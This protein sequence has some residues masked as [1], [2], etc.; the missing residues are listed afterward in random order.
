M[1]TTVIYATFDG[2][3][4]MQHG[5]GTQARAFVSALA[6]IELAGEIEVTVAY[7]E[8]LSDC[9]GYVRSADVHAATVEACRAA[10]VGLTPLRFENAR[11]WQQGAWLEI[12]T[13]LV[14][15]IGELREQGRRVVVLAVDAVF[16]PL[17]TLTA[18]AFGRDEQLDLVHVLYSS[19]R[20]EGAK[21]DPMREAWEQ[22]A[23]TSVNDREGNH[24]AGIGSSFTAH[25]RDAYGLLADPIPFRQSVALSDP[26]LAP[27]DTESASGILQRA[28]IPQERPLVVAA[29]RSDPIKG[30][31]DMADAL[32]LVD[33]DVLFVVIAVPYHEEDPHLAALAS[34]LEA[35]GRDYV[36]ISHFDRA[37]LRAL[38]STA[39]TKALVVPSRGEPVGMAPQ[40]VAL[41]AH[42]FG[43][44]VVASDCDGLAE[45]IDHGADGFLFAPGDA[46]AMA[47]AID[48]A[49]T[50]D[51]E[52]HSRMRRQL[53]QRVARERDFVENLSGLFEA[54]DIRGRRRSPRED[55]ETIR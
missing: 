3:T 37:L 7:P 48:L 55:E 53:A 41:W 35:S 45:Q 20:V 15:V 46:E 43:P 1:K 47:A 40:E 11:L 13:S 44:V 18:A 2:V 36:L 16:T 28:H 5:I 50:L 26:E 23:I 17:S 25:L 14:R 34:K 22:I 9:V 21:R 19:A 32:H 54:L 27:L 31:Q 49:V 10:G 4:T 52:H 8:P 29:A 38:S 42:R 33:S 39:L 51:E 6:E 12:C 24:I 30:L